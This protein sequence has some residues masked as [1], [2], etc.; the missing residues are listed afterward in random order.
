[1][2]IGGSTATVFAYVLVSTGVILRSWG[3]CS[4]SDGS[5]VGSASA[6]DGAEK[7][8]RRAAR[9]P[10]SRMRERL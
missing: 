4:W 7:S 1:M 5:S 6:A 10:Q 2:T 3:P 9:K 8:N